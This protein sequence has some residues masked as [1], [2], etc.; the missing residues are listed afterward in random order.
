MPRSLADLLVLNDQNLAPQEVSD[1]LEGA[2]LLMWLAATISSNGHK[3]SYL[4]KTGAPSVGYR[5]IG[6]GLAASNATRVK[7]ETELKILSA[8][9]E[10]DAREAD[11]YQFGRAEY[12]ARDVRDH[13]QAA[14]VDTE[15]QIINGT[16]GNQADG[17][18]GF[19]DALAAL[20]HAMVVNAGG[21]VAGNIVSSVWLIKS[22]DMHEDVA[23]VGKG[24][25]T[26]PENAR[27]QIQLGDTIE[28]ALTDANGNNYPGL[29]T[30]CEGWL[31][32]QVGSAYSIARLANVTDE[33]GA[34]LTDNLLSQLWAKIPASHRGNRENWRFVMNPTLQMQLQQSRTATSESGKEADIPDNWQGIQFVV[35]DNVPTNETLLA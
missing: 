27:I 4:A 22:T 17:Y 28:Q 2:P 33:S 34:T 30:P 20:N 6:T 9:S 8:N 7:R 15:K 14:F 32:V 35:T 29:F 3:H 25:G 23:I 21:T 31:G 16:V 18:T 24:E 5:T 13:L 12:V 19:A 10:V 26:N 1:I 11:I